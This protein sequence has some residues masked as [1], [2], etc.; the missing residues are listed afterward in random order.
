MVIF[1]KLVNFPAFIMIIAENRWIV[2]KIIAFMA[3]RFSENTLFAF[4]IT[5]KKKTSVETLNFYS[6]RNHFSL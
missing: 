4:D 2:K 1:C 3:C 6:M 5:R